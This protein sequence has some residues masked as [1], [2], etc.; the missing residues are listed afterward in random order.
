LRRAK[1]KHFCLKRIQQQEHNQLGEMRTKINNPIDNYH[2]GY[3]IFGVVGLLL[4]KTFV[5]QFFLVPIESTIVFKQQHVNT[6][7]QNHE[8]KIIRYIVGYF[9]EI[10]RPTL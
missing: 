5:Y 10:E 1:E 4:L 6:H 7:N 8:Q 3:S 9:G 2:F